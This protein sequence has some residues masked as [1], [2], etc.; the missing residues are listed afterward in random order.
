MLQDEVVVP[1]AMRSLLAPA[2]ME[3]SRLCE[4][5]T[6][7][8]GPTAATRMPTGRS[9]G[10]AKDG[11]TSG[12]TAEPY[13]WGLELP[14]HRLGPRTARSCFPLARLGESCLTTARETVDMLRS[15]REGLGPSIRNRRPD[16]PSGSRLLGLT[17]RG[18]RNP[19]ELRGTGDWLQPLH[20]A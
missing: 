5:G 11:E 6:D 4:G 1:V 16:R 2:R 12:S 13:V 14:P 19:C 10:S 7:L 18:V 9:W 15:E 17:C 20:Q 8:L 3:L